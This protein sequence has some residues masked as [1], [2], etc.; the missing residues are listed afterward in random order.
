MKFFLFW[1]NKFYTILYLQ[2]HLWLCSFHFQWLNRIKREIL[3]TSTPFSVI[4]KSWSTS[5]GKAWDA[6]IFFLYKWWWTNLRCL[7]GQD[8]QKRRQ[9]CCWCWWFPHVFTSE[10]LEQ[11]NWQLKVNND[12][13]RYCFLPFNKLENSSPRALHCC[14]PCNLLFLVAGPWTVQE[15]WPSSPKHLDRRLGLQYRS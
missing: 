12:C 14:G 13:D 15:R 5:I 3:S 11:D 8:I 6:C 7:T 9:I 2:R 1:L 10:K 4:Y